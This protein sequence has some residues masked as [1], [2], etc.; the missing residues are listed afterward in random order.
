[1]KAGDVAFQSLLDD[2]VQYLV[3]L[4]QRPYR[5]G[6]EQWGK[7]WDDLIDVYEVTDPAKH[8]IGS[9]V[10]Q[11]ITT[12]PED[13][14]KY[15]LIDG[16]QR[17]TSLFI[18]LSVIRRAA[19]DRGDTSHLADEIQNSCLINQYARTPDERD[20]LVPTQVD[21]AA[22]TSLINDHVPTLDTAIGRAT[23]Y[24]TK[25]LSDGDSEGNELCLRTLYDCIVGRLD[26]VSIHLENSDSPNRIFES[27]NNTGMPLNVADLIRNFLL[28]NIPNPQQQENAYNTYWRPMEKLL[29]DDRRDKSPDFFWRYLMMDGSLPRI[30]DTYDAIQKLKCLRNPNAQKVEAALEDFKRYARHYAQIAGLSNEGID[31]NALEGVQRLNQWVADVAYPPLMRLFNA[32]ESKAISNNDLCEVIGMIESF[33]VRRGVC[34][35]PTNQLRRV[36]GLMSG[37]VDSHYGDITGFTREHLSNNRWPSDDEFRSKF[38]DFHLY[39]RGRL[40]R[41]RLVLDSLERSF[42]HKET[43]DLT[44]DKITIEHIMP[45]SLSD[46][47]KNALVPD[48]SETHTQWLDTVGNL[49]LTGYNSELGNCPFHEKKDMLADSNFALSA[50]IL[51]VENWDAT[52]IQQRGELLADRALGIWK[53]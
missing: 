38:V 31:K 42:G 22:F 12:A 7:L 15:T 45:Q 2:K 34:G 50:S 14:K 53:R 37:Q 29:S 21:R 47:W 49:T 30:E 19:L 44:G 3:P 27:L 41:T 10:T 48:Y 32:L 1:M 40:G 36:F 11:Q 23:A 51:Q 6:E 13:A 25:A 46:W 4:F 18:I 35:I 24:F 33:L 20:K 28:M 26:M 52:A 9:V 5:W 8:F 43:P 39:T 17:M 16:Q